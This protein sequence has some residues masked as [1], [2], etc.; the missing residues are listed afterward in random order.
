VAR[1]RQEALARRAEDH[2]QRD[3]R[4]HRPGGEEGAPEDRPALRL[5]R[6]PG[7]DAVLEEQQP[8]DREDDVGRAGEHLDRA[9]DLVFGPTLGRIPLEPLDSRLVV[10]RR[11]P[12]DAN[13]RALTE[14]PAG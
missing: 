13:S 10:A 1:D 2:R 9:P 6:Q 5:E 12:G 7:E 14:F 4:H 11:V 3:E 8:E